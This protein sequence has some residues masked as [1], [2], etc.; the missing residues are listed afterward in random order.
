MM[1][2]YTACLVK[3]CGSSATDVRFSNKSAAG[4]ILPTHTHIGDKIDTSQKVFLLTKTF[5]TNKVNKIN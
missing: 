2:N 4:P 1:M 3:D 5:G